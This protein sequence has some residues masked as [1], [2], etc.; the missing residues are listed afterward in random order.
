MQW[1][2][3]LDSESITELSQ[4][5]YILKTVNYPIIVCNS[6]ENLYRVEIDADADP[7]NIAENFQL[8]VNYA[9]ITSNGSNVNEYFLIDI[10]NFDLFDNFWEKIENDARLVSFFLK[11]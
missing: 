5:K 8:E 10:L 9:Y 11:S 2:Y 6:F 7:S 4:R 3:Y 1:F